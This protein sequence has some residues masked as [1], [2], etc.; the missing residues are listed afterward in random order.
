MLRLFS[1]SAA[2]QT[3]NPG[4]SKDRRRSADRLPKFDINCDLGEGEKPA[5]VRALMK[6]ITSANVACGGHAGGV[7]SMEYCV[8]QS[9]GWGVRLGAHPGY[10][11]RENFGRTSQDIT[12]AELE[13]LLIQQVS[14]L[15]KVAKL[16]SMRIHHI[17]LHG[18]LYHDVERDSGLATVYSETVARYWPK[19]KI[20]ATANGR[21]KRTAESNGVTVWE[22]AFAD[23]AY[24]SDGTLV[25][26][27]VAGAVLG[28]PKLVVERLRGIFRNR[29]METISGS[30][31]EMA[32]RTVCVHSDTPEAVHIAK[33]I[34][35]ELG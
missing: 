5:R 12:P 35:T 15:E 9:R 24:M 17:K 16:G 14:G 34:S 20:Y 6:W 22:E 10:W 32:P 3:T 25:P 13:L 29:K 21:V 18:A 7:R 19:A 27:N 33:A 26:R 2:Q 8:R 1:S 30:H 11:D 4:P 28:D 23:R 31:I